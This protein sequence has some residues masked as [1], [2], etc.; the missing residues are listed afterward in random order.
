MNVVEIDQDI[1]YLSIV[2]VLY[3]EYNEPSL[4]KVDRISQQGSVDVT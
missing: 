2:F 3:N 1:N 4:G